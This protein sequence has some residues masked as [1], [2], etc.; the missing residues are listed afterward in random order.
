MTLV[1][2]VLMI[3][4]LI[5]DPEYVMP[6]FSTTF[7]IILLFIMLILQAIGGVVIKRVVTI[8]V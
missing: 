2:F 1:P 4:F 8:K 7:G 3:G 5:F 6:M